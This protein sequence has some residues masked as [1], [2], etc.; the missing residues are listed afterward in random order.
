MRFAISVLVLGA[1]S[2]ALALDFASWPSSEPVDRE[3]RQNFRKP[4]D[5]WDHVVK[6]A[7][8]QAQRSYE[9][10]NYNLRANSVD[11]S[12][13][14]VDTVKQYSGYL[15][16]TESDKHL[17]YCESSPLI[18][19]IQ[20]SSPS[21]TVVAGFFESRNDPANDPVVLW[22]NGGPGCSSLTGLFL[23]L[24]PATID[25]NLQ[26]VENPY[27][28]NSNASVIFLDQPVNV[29]FSYSNQQ[30]NTT[31]AA[32]KDVYALLTLFFHQFPEYA[33]QPFH[34]AG[35]SYAG[36]YIPIFSQEILS[37]GDRNINLQG[38]MIGNGLTDPLTQYRYY[39]PMACGDGGYPAVLDESACQFMDDALPL[40]ESMI[41]FCHDSGDADVC[42]SATAFC[43]RMMIGPYDQAGKNVYDVRKNCEGGDLCYTA[44]GY[45][46]EWLNKEEVMQALGVE[47]NGYQSCNYAINLDFIP[48]LIY[49]GDAD[50]ICNWLGNQA[51][52]NA[53]DWPGHDDFNNATLQPLVTANGG[54]EYGQ[55][56]SAMNFTFMRIFGA[57]HM[58]PMEQPEASL[59]FL[60]RWLAGEWVS[61]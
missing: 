40:C 28:W 23:E 13:L 30:V 36:H 42:S 19:A 32:S 12:G 49:A 20:P 52:T 59:D 50:F 25:K 27:S 45:I 47:V 5:Q 48:V 33:E 1:A 7:D 53:L 29:G 34:I 58:T 21:L 24:G 17:F 60:N 14:G 61:M 11:P 51:W 10:A 54:R 55:V 38:A 8:V 15:D 9:L 56:R 16:I 6:G 3:P 22:L 41:Q 46:S 37:H 57:G 26:V 31:V 4:D 18:R 43:N 35:E 2:S 39:R 44:L